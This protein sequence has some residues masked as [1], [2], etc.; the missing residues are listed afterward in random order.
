MSEVEANT[1]PPQPLKIKAF[2]Q[3]WQEAGNEAGNESVKDLSG[4][5]LKGNNPSSHIGHRP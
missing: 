2:T 4:K 3:T 1:Q 5:Y